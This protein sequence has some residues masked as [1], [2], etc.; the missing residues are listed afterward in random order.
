MNPAGGNRDSFESTF[1][2][3]GV[4][5]FLRSA[6]DEVTMMLKKMKI[7]GL[8]VLFLLLI[9][10]AGQ[11]EVSRNLKKIT[12]YT[13]RN[14]VL[15]QSYVDGSGNIVVADDLGY[16]TLR[17]TYTTGTKLYKTEYFDAEG[18][19]I[20]TVWGFFQQTC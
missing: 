2:K 11:A 20:N 9:A 12:T 17:N 7:G 3:G 4:S 14:K 16:A 13:T 18:K 10:M 8:A 6:I 5:F 1:L 19:P 15:E